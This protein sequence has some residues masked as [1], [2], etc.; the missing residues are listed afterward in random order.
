MNLTKF[1]II[2]GLCILIGNCDIFG[3]HI[4]IGDYEDQLEAWNNMNML[5]YQLS[6]SH[7][8]INSL[9]R[10]AVIT[11]RNG[12]PESSDPPEWLTSGEKST[13]PEFFSFINDE[14]NKI[15]SGYLS[16]Y[17]DTEYHYPIDIHKSPLIGD[18]FEYVWFIKLTPLWKLGKLD[19]DIGDY[20][21]EL[22]AWNSQNMLDY[23]IEVTRDYRSKT[24]YIL[25]NV[26][27]GIIENLN[28]YYVYSYVRTI[29][30]YY[31]LI[32]GEE[33]MLRN[34]Y[35][36]DNSKSFSLKVRYN[37]EYHYPGEIIK[38]TD[39]VLDFG[40]KITL[41]PHEETE[42]DEEGNHE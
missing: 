5:D 18:D 35:N 19:I 14:K 12:I 33:E 11:V 22:A 7:Y 2:F 6:L 36:R 8:G 32:K 1:F 30:E 24:E 27:N 25:I 20:E 17:Y 40:L 15:K 9:T 31:S 21:G 4:Q 23:W 37:T 16:A 3:P 39:G 38:K 13:I 28:P 26:E 42:G 29:P 34:A 41:N 10:R